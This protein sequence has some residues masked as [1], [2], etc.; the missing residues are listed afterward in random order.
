MALGAGFGIIAVFLL[1]L[2]GFRNWPWL[3]GSKPSFR[4]DSPTVITVTVIDRA[5]IGSMQGNAYSKVIDSGSL[6]V[7]IIKGLAEAQKSVEHQCLTAGKITVQYADGGSLQLGFLPGH[8]P[9]RYE[10]RYNGALYSL[11]RSQF[12]DVMQSAG[13]EKSEIPQK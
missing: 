12:L 8:Y 3:L 11:P 9:K 7:N 10:F 1:A 13:V 2:F 5:Q 6:C 4:L